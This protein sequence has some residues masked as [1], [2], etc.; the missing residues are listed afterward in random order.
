M[1]RRNR[2]IAALAAAAIGV[3]AIAPGATALPLP[4]AGPAAGAVVDDNLVL[5]Q[6]RQPPQHPHG[7]GYYHHRGHPYYNG[8]RGYRDY[9]PGYRQYNGWWFPPAAF[10]LGLFLGQGMAQPAPR[11]LPAAHY[12]WCQRRYKSYRA[13]DNTFQPYNGPRR[14]CRS[15][16]WP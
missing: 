13:Y 9:R 5:V 7:K 6:K 4:K 2:L 14:A 11:G 10:A 8:H 16:Y 1:T 3:A 12:N 15:P